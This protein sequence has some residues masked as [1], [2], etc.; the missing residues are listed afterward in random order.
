MVLTAIESIRI[1][2]AMM[3]SAAYK[4]KT[5]SWNTVD[6]TTV[7]Q[8]V[9]TAGPTSWPSKGNLS[10]RVSEDDQGT[11]KRARDDDGQAR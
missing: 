5:R 4:M 1:V 10:R 11:H 7:A 9:A 8:A 2:T 6:T 3:C